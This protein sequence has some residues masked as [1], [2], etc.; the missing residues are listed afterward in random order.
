[1]RPP[2]LLRSAADLVYRPV[3][4]AAQARFARRF[5]ADVGGH[6]YLDDA[7]IATGGKTFYEGTAPLPTELALRRLGLRR[8]DV[9]ADLGCGKGAAL[10]LAAE[11]D[12]ERVVGVE[13]GE[14]LAAV[15]RRNLAANRGR[16][17]AR[18]LDVEAVD[19]TCW[20]VPDELSVVFLYCP[21]LGDLFSQVMDRVIASYDARPRPLRIVYNYPWEHARLLATGRVR[22][23]DV[24]PGNLR[25][26]PGWW[27]RGEVIVT[28]QVVG[29]DGTAP[30]VPSP[31]RVNPRAVR[32]WSAP[33]ETRFFLERPGV[34]T[35]YSHPHDH[36]S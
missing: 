10:L 24:F 6:D 25:P 27:R 19:A 28:Y 23:V 32:Y 9:F 5:D 3:A 18:R 36:A 7:A 30:P 26:R 2:T 16:L 13:L 14:D 20:E 17:R 29:A 1:V 22:T 35:L 15:A 33:N 11:H 12:I 8:H 21:F 34:P 31:R 4:R